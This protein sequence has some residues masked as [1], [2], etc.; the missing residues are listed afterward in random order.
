MASDFF[1]V[2][3]VSLVMGIEGKAGSIEVTLFPLLIGYL[4]DTYKAIGNIIAGY[5]ILFT[6]CSVAYLVSLVIIHF[7]TCK[8]ERLMLEQIQ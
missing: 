4:L 3:A 5:N 7:L 8:S 6:P 2:E 1:P